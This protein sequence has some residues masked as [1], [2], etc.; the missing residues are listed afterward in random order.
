MSSL[1]DSEAK[2]FHSSYVTGL[3]GFVGIAIVVHYLFYVWKLWF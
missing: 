2:E 1:S 3:L